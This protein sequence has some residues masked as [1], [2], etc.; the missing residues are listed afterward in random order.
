MK[1]IKPT[2]TGEAQEIRIKVRITD[3]G[4][5]SVTGANAVEKK[6]VKD[7]ETPQGE[8]PAGNPDGGNNMDTT[9]VSLNLI[10][11]IRTALFNANSVSDILE[12]WIKKTTVA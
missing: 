3:N 4:L 5:I 6:A 10:N 2:A 11:I 8:T 1:N 9:E 7:P 12:T